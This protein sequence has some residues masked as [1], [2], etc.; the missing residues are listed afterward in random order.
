MS[1][2]IVTRP[3]DRRPR[4]RDFEAWQGQ[5]I[6]LFRTGASLAVEHT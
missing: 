5:Q 1:E 4:T 3:R 2:R 6:F